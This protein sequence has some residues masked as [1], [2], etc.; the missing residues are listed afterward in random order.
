[1]FIFFYC[2]VAGQRV[3]LQLKRVVDLEGLLISQYDGKKSTCVALLLSS[4]ALT[5]FELSFT[6]TPAQNL[7]SKFSF[8]EGPC[9]ISPEAQLG[10]HYDA[11]SGPT[12]KP[13]KQGVKA[14]RL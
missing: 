8:Q 2:L 10:Q 11:H 1:M 14:M 6:S 3:C 4:L 12:R 9:S 7:A 13:H 5:H